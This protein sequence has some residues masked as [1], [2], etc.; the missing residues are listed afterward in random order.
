MNAATAAAMN[1]DFMTAA[2]REHDPEYA[3]AVPHQPGL[4][5][6]THGDPL[7]VVARTRFVRSER[8]AADGHS[9]P[10]VAGK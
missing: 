8:A 10:T 2:S 3:S 5:Q 7:P 1:L 4:P 9:T 6:R